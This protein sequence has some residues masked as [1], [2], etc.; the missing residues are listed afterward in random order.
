[1][2][3][4]LQTGTGRRPRGPQER[5]GMIRVKVD[6]KSRRNV[7][8]ACRVTACYRPWPCPLPPPVG[9]FGPFG[10]LW[11]SD[12]F[13]GLAPGALGSPGPSSGVVGLD[14]TLGLLPASRPG[15]PRAPC[16]CAGSRSYG[17]AGAGRG[18]CC[19]RGGRRHASVVGGIVSAGGHRYAHF[20][21]QGG[22]KV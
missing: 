10:P 12:L 2:L 8:A 15:R 6:G 20:A 11:P 22:R 17:G 16:S 21:E 1:E 18:R 13:V 9:P 4:S 7:P 14:A 5:R 3:L 19:R